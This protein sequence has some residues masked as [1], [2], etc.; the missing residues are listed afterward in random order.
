M[1]IKVTIR[2]ACTQEL[3]IKGI[4]EISD[5]NKDVSIVDFIKSK[6]PHHPDKVLVSSFES[7]DGFSFMNGETLNSSIGEYLDLI[8]DEKSKQIIASVDVSGV[9]PNIK[10]E[11]VTGATKYDEETV[12]SGEEEDF[13]TAQDNGNSTWKQERNEGVP[14]EN[15]ISA[16]TYYASEIS[17]DKAEAP[18]KK[19]ELGE[20][21]AMNVLL[22]EAPVA[23]DDET[24]MHLDY[25]T[26][27][28][29]SNQRQSVIYNNGNQ[30][31]PCVKNAAEKDRRSIKRNREKRDIKLLDKFLENEDRGKKQEEKNDI[32]QDE[33]EEK[34]STTK[35]IKD[36][37]MHKNDMKDM[38]KAPEA[39][40]A[41][42]GQKQVDVSLKVVE[43]LRSYQENASKFTLTHDAVD[44]LE[45]F[46]MQFKERCISVSNNEIP[47]PKVTSPRSNVTKLVSAMKTRPSVAKVTTKKKLTP[48][49]IPRPTPT[50][51]PRPAPK[52][53]P[54]FIPRA[55]PKF[56][57]PRAT[58]KFIPRA[59]KNQQTIQLRKAR[60]A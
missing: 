14:H 2:S 51:I 13:A 56:I 25:G 9:T 34:S 40:A 24:V 54:N 41:A 11:D 53:I 12:F 60:K 42:L 22:S 33:K 15:G 36:G 26:T 37:R 30:R 45:S 49:Y 17:A 43:K 44:A 28:P 31:A 10:I 3:I 20:N 35:L 29:L 52:F 39:D 16:G 18:A 55:T 23:N 21:S 46:A 58:P 8:S 50:F 6:C 27:V 1:L 57:P 32:K 47:V 4:Y 48:I 7:A 19:C 59:V 5:A 38:I